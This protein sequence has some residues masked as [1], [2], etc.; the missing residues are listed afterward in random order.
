MLADP[1][2]AAEWVEQ[3][4]DPSARANTAGLVFFFWNIEN[5]VASHAWLRAL[6][7]V[8]ETRRA[9]ILRPRK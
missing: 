2:T 9:E 4:A 3:I 7:G 5:P 8:D 6:P 1:P